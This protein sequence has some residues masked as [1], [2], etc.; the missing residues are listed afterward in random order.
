MRFCILSGIRDAVSFSLR[1]LCYSLPFF[2]LFY[3]T[4]FYDNYLKSVGAG[5]TYLHAFNSIIPLKLK[6]L[7]TAFCPPVL[8][9][10]PIRRRP[11]RYSFR[12]HILYR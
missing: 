9:T 12:S 11:L 4:S 5:L 6:S 1:C 2:H 3:I 7:Y 8:R 10:N